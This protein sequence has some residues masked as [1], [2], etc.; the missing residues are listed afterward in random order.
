MG[1]KEKMAELR[2]EEGMKNTQMKEA[3]LDAVDGTVRK[4]VCWNRL[5]V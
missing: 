5:S 2:S 1:E 3:R 4:V